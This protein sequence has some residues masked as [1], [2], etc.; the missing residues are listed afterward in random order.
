MLLTRSPLIRPASW[1][2]SFDLH[3]LSTPPAFILSQDQTLRK[4]LQNDT[5][6]AGNNHRCIHSITWRT[7][8]TTHGGAGTLV[9]QCVKTI[10]I[11]K[12]GTLLSS[13][14][15][16]AAGFSTTHSRRFAPEQLLH[17]RPSGSPCQHRSRRHHDPFDSSS[18]GFTTLARS[19]LLSTPCSEPDT[20]RSPWQAHKPYHDE[21]RFGKPDHLFRN[22]VSH[23]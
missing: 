7:R 6:T 12:L 20:S 9:N 16:D 11:K 22:T 18:E 15:T 1:A 2:S 5:P 19:T 17:S 14:T 23:P 21:T 8:C 3:V 13:Q 4:K 10:G